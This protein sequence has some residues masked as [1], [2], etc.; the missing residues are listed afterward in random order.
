VFIN[1]QIHKNA[2]ATTILLASLC[3]DEYNKVSGLDNAKQIWD[4]LK[5]SHEG[6]DATRRSSTTIRGEEP[7]Q[8]YNRLK[9]LVN[10]IRSYGSTRWMDHD[11][12]QLMLRSFT[13]IDPH[14]VNLIRENPRYT[15]MT[16]EEI[17]GKFVSGHMMVKEERYVD[18]AFNGPMPIYEPQPV[19]LKATSSNEALPSKVA[20]VEAAGLNRN[21][22]VLIIKR[23]KTALKGRKEHPNKNKTRGKRS[24]FKCGKTGHFIANCPDNDSDQG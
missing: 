13:V 2:Q 9:T 15:K 14:L 10:K 16:P 23:F 20:Q 17:L 11:V 7:T 1:E 22:M 3:R 8:M 5:I 21:E 18:D 6:N 12:V 4:T 19:A 24:Y